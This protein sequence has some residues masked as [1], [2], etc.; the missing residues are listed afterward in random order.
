MLF[1]CLALGL[2]FTKR[3]FNLSGDDRRF[4]TIA[5]W[6]CWAMAAAF[7]VG[8]LVFEKYRSRKAW[9]VCC[10]SER[11]VSCPRLGKVFQI[12]NV[13]G[14]QLITGSFKW[15]DVDGPVTMQMTQLNLI[16]QEGGRLQRYPLIG[17]H[18]SG[19]LSKHAEFLSEHCGIRFLKDTALTVADWT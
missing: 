5:A 12:D 3:W 2:H 9:F 17:D 15:R 13:E 18:N 7:L 16:A 14:M 1:T 6:F 8:T 10:P 4:C 19:R 11:T